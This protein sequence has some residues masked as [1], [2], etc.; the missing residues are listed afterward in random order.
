MSIWLIEDDSNTVG[1]GN[2]K[3]SFD[4]SDDEVK[5][6]NS[7]DY[8]NNVVSTE[9]LI[10]KDSDFLRILRVK[11]VNRLN[12]VSNKFDQLKLFVQGKVDILIFTEKKLDSTFPTSQFMIDG[13]TEPYRFH[14]NRNGGEVLIYIRE[15]IPSN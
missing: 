3:H 8:N 4:F 14:R 1:K 2:C 6:N 11:N 9:K 12:S 7:I 13:Y 10:E 5:H 15:E